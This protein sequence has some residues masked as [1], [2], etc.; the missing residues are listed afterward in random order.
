MDFH[1]SIYSTPLLFGFVQAWIYALLLWVRG[2]REERLSDSLLGWILIALALNIWMYMLGF[3]GIEIFWR[4]LNFFP[5]TISLLLPPLIY[6]YL[7]AQFDA[8]FRLRPRHLWHGLPF[9]VQ[10]VYHMIV[11]S[12][13]GD[14]V[15][16]WETNVH[17]RGV[18]DLEFWVGTVQSLVYL[19][20]SFRL[21]RA[22]RNWVGTQFSDTER[23]SFRWF[24]N[25]LVAL[26]VTLIVDL[27]IT[28]V[29]RV[30][31]LSY[32]ED[33]WGNLVGV[34]LIYYVSIEGYAQTQVSHRLRFDPEQSDGPKPEQSDKPLPTDLEEQTSQ[35][36]T[37]MTE[38]R[39]YLDGDLSLAELARRLH[40][41]AAVLSQVINTGT[42]SNFNDFVNGYRVAEFKRRVRSP[43]VGHLSFLGLALECGFNSKST[44]NRAFRKATGMS[45]KAYV[46]EHP[47][48]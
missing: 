15:R 14:F 20:W 38:E 1:F 3:G 17:Y 5:R 6:F 26:T 43:S 11:F 35:L 39:P 33:W 30:L 21:Y 7:R 23:I 19:Y 9:V 24:R 2:W 37:Y 28:A 22:Y 36:L 13:G 40:T 25:F 41:N 46:S 31:D 48:G 18:A 12:R 4:E 47:A 27:A 34:A 32:W 44:F 16:Y 45:P 42:G 8:G 10:S 29:D